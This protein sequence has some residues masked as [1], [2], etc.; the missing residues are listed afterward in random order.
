MQINMHLAD[1][2]INRQRPLAGRFR[3]VAAPG[4]ARCRA[5]QGPPPAGVAESRLPPVPAGGTDSSLTI[6]LKHG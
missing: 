5:G 2:S 1:A 6:V 3:G 4:T